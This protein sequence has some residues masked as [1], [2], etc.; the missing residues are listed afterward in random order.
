MIIQKQTSIDVQYENQTAFAV[1]NHACYKFQKNT[2]RNY[3]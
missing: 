2:I 3:E 1:R